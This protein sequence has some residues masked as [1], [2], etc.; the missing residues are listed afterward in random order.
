MN[1]IFLILQLSIYLFIYLYF[2]F[3]DNIQR[4]SAS[5]Y[6]PSVEDVLRARNKTTG[7]IE[8]RFNMGQLNI[9]Y[10]FF[11]FKIL[12]SLNKLFDHNISQM[13]HIVHAT[14]KLGRQFRRKCTYSN[15]HIYIAEK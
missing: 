5:N 3:F 4:I 11:N 12:N 15:A 6:V 10:I 7:I 14:C 9:Q 13:P 1:F 2:S 8:T